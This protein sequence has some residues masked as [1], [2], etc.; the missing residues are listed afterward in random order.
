MRSQLQQRKARRK[1]EASPLT[2]PRNH[3][4]SDRS[5]KEESQDRA[6]SLLAWLISIT[7]ETA[8][9]FSIWSTRE[10][11]Q[12][13]IQTSLSLASKWISGRTRTSQSTTLSSRSRSLQSSSSVPGSSGVWPRK[14][15]A[16]W[17]Q[18]TRKSSMTSLRRPIPTSCFISSTYT[19]STR[20]R[21]G[22]AVSEISR[23]F[24]RD[25]RHL[26][27]AQRRKRRN[28]SDS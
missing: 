5:W 25:R 23:G 21:S 27:R 14:T 17:T 28:Q 8:R 12:L 20:Q 18:S 24:P 13:D 4:C 10:A 16:C 22:S 2:R 11:T 9:S 15:S 6:T 7:L 19:A 3:L 26:R 1:Q